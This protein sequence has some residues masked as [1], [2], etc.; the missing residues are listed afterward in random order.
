[1]HALQFDV[2]I[3]N[4]EREVQGL[5]KVDVGALDRVHVFSCSLEL[6]ELE[7]LGEHLHLL[8]NNLAN[9]LIDIV[10]IRFKGAF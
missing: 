10:T 9:C 8:I 5:T 2:R 4:L 1:M 3:V 6:V 7:V